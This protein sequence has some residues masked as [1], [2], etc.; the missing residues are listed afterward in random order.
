M[1]KGFLLLGIDTD[2][3]QIKYAYTTALSIKT[4]DPEAS[5]CLIVADIEKDLI[6]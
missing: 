5:I 3:D 6:T 1:S 4:C 2:Q